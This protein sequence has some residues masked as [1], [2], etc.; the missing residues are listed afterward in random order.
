MVIRNVKT[1]ERSVV[2]CEA[3][4]IAIGH[5]PDTKIFTG[6]LELD[7]NGYIVTRDLLK[8]SVE[9]IFAAGKVMDK[10]CRQAASSA[11]FGCIASLEAIEY[12]EAL[13]K[14]EQVKC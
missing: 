14:E 6:W 4:L 8:T 5:V 3:I 2:T 9:G 12:V 13:K 11:G 10:R 1:G 7:E